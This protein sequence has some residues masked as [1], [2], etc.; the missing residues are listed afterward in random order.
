MIGPERLMSSPK[1]QI[2]V[3]GGGFSGVRTAMM[4]EKMLRPE[5]ASV[6]LIN[7][8]NY[9]VFRPLLPEVVSL[10]IG[11]TGTISPIRRL[12]SR[13]DLVMRAV[14]EIDLKDQ[15][16]TVSSGFRPRRPQ[17]RYDY[18]VIAL[19]SVTDF[20]GV[21]GMLEHA[22]PFRTLADA[23][24][25]R[26]HV[27]RVLEEANFETDAEFRKKLLT[28]VVAGAG[29]SG[30][31]L[32]AELN[33]FVRAAAKHYRHISREEVCCVLVH[34]G[35]RILPEMA[36][37]LASFA[38][39]QLSKRGIQ[40]VL[41]DCLVAATSE[42]AV[43]E[44]GGEIT[45]NTIISTVPSTLPQVLQDLDCAKDKGRLSANLYLELNGHEGNVWVVG[46]CASS[47]TI[48]GNP[49]PPAAR[50]ATRQAT[51]VAKNICATIRRGKK[52][53]FA[54]E[55]LG[56][57][58][59]LGH[60]NAVANVCGIQISGFAPWVVWRTVYLMKM[61]GWNRKAHL[62]TDWLMHL[63]FPPDLVQ[64]RASSASGIAEQYFRTGET[65]FNE[66][67]MGD[68]VYMIQQGECEVFKL[69]QGRH[70]SVAVL[71]SGEYFGEM[72][73]LSDKRRSATVK[74]VTPSRLLLIPKEDFDLI[75]SSVPAFGSFFSELAQSR[76]AS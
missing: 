42:K 19:G 39:R 61:P 7:R 46:D 74:A 58:A 47:N 75:R 14:E 9:L 49:V 60:H 67:D 45:C 31:E 64:F 72:A 76:P 52:S 41:N 27:I 17:L 21:P 66:G 5:E 50:H 70:Q 15:V 1:K 3:L 30:I 12:C 16:V 63:L 20:N 53:A 22:K 25:L 6:T 73:L 68:S 69:K 43:L 29:F 36:A 10:S 51:T 40:I 55:G 2:L 24:A 28:F 62:A 13:T 34:S 18:L 4:L 54:F 59:P 11:L 48:S 44:K 35:P 37:G 71:K 26:N 38:Q 23:I 65:V 57:L 33:D 8:E 32:V 56:K